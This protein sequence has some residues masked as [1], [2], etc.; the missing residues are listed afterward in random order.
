M[1][2]YYV[3]AGDKYY[4]LG[5][6]K[7]YQGLTNEIEEEKKEIE[8]N[9]EDYDWAHF[10]DSYT[11]EIIEEGRADYPGGDFRKKKEWTWEK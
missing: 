6:M 5:G 10:V 2:Y 8:N 11:L 9:S 7:D 3:F 1:K 4:P